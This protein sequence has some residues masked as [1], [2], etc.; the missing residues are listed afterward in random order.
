MVR[1]GMRSV[2]VS[3]AIAAIAATVAAGCGDDDGDASTSTTST[4]ATESPPPAELLGTYAMHLKP[5]DVPPNPPPELTDEAESWTLKITKTGALGGGPALTIIND[6][7]G[8]LE[9]SPVGVQGDHILIH[10][11]EC[12]VS[13]APVESEYEWALDGDELRFTAVENGC[14]DDVVLTLLAA[15]P[16]L[17]RG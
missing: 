8:Q 10:D 13:T 7:L 6:V 3:V 16:W 12:A 9:S 15:E 1:R 5:S 14:A 17:R 2:V 4:A 11:E